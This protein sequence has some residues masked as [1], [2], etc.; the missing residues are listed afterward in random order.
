[1]TAYE[2]RISDWSSDVCSSDLLGAKPHIIDSLQVNN[3]GAFTHGLDQIPNARLYIEFINERLDLLRRDTIPLHIVDARDYQ[4]LSRHLGDIAPDV[5]I[6]LAAVAH[7]NRANKDPYS[8]FDHSMRTL[9]K[10]GRAHV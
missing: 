1:M 4:L 8:T 9:E 6:Q 10:I 3:L 7:A 2:M 5:V